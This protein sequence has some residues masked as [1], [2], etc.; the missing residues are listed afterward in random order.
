MKNTKK[1]GIDAQ[2][3]TQRI[4]DFPVGTGSYAQE[5]MAEHIKRF[6]TTAEGKTET[7]D[8]LAKGLADRKSGL[9]WKEVIATS[10]QGK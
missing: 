1:F 4:T 8:K 6:G 10:E 3:V 9:G 7:F 2:T 5:V